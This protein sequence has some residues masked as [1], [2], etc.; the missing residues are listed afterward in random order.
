VNEL[1]FVLILPDSWD[2]RITSLNNVVISV[3][4][5]DV[6]ELTDA[7]KLLTD[8]VKLLIDC[9]CALK[10]VS[11]N[12]PV[13]IGSPLSDIEPDITTEPVKL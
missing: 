6:N 5:D 3:P 12:L 7:V 9:V 10:V 4:A 8:A 13:P 11:S 2:K 1:K